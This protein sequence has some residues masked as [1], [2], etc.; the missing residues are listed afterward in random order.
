MTS[1][2]KNTKPSQNQYISPREEEELRWKGVIEEMFFRFLK[3]VWSRECRSVSVMS[4]DM[5]FSE[6][7]VS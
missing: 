3:K 1:E 7:T 6:K 2:M 5:K 4:I